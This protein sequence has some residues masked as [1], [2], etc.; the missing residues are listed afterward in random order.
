M[1]FP[2]P[3]HHQL[4]TFVRHLYK[5]NFDFNF[6]PTIF[7]KFFHPWPNKFHSSS[8]RNSGSRPILFFSVHPIFPPYSRV[9]FLVYYYLR[10]TN[11]RS[12]IKFYPH[13]SRLIPP[14]A[15][16]RK[17]QKFFHSTHKLHERQQIS[18]TSHLCNPLTSPS[19]RSLVHRA[20]ERSRRRAGGKPR[21]ISPNDSTANLRPLSFFPH[22]ISLPFLT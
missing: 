4:F 10:T 15:H 13:T 21:I 7:R 11:S 14:S 3:S 18:F 16:K 12:A 17:P 2:Y 19:P 20:R 22:K 6:Y 9:N 1:I 8:S 5:Y